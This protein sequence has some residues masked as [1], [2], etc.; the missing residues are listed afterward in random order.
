MV[1]ARFLSPARLAT[2]VA[3]ITPATTGMRAAGPSA[4]STPA[5]IPAAGQ[6]TATPSRSVSR[7]RL[8]RAARKYTI[9]IAAAI[10]I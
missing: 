5:E 9:P 4:T 7:K 8:T 6:N 10:P 2:T 1:L 3:P